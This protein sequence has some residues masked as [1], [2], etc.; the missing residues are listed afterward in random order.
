MK[1][2]NYKVMVYDAFIYI[3]IYD[4]N[5]IGE[6]LVLGVNNKFLNGLTQ[7]NEAWVIGIKWVGLG[8]T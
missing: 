6:N 2:I 7:M 4:Y 8:C 5:Y 3:Y 1:L